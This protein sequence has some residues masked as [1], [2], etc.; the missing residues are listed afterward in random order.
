MP[1]STLPL[2]EVNPQCA[3]LWS[4]KLQWCQGLS[5]LPICS[6]VT[7]FLILCVYFPHMSNIN[8]L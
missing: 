8:Q 2:P 6:W 1:T 3:I 7:S 5:L 4:L